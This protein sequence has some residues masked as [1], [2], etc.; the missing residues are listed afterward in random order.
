[1]C[2][3]DGGPKNAMSTPCPVLTGIIGAAFD[4]GQDDYF[5]PAPAPGS[6]LATH[7][8][9]YDSAFLE[10][11]VDVGVGGDP[12][13]AHTAAAPVRTVRRLHAVLRTPGGTRA[14][15]AILEVSRASA[16]RIVLVEPALGLR[17]RGA[18][19]RASLR[20]VLCAW[21]ATARGRVLGIRRCVSHAGTPG[22]GHTAL[23]HLPRLRLAT[24]SGHLRTSLSVL[25]RDTSGN[26][27]PF[28]STA[29]RGLPVAL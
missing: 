8:N 4:C 14:G 28:A 16:G 3:A 15:L 23:L 25:A 11:A 10:R 1:M 29:A 24:H 13:A 26:W 18:P 7:W 5:N 19:H 9:V 22:A 17:L 12:P 20:V 21:H 2:Y 27:R 6:Y